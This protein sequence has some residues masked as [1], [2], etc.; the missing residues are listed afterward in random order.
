[1]FGVSKTEVLNVIVTS[2]NF[3]NDI[4]SLLDLWPS[5]KLVDFYMPQSLKELYPL[6][7]IIIDT[8]STFSSYKHKNTLKFLVGASPGGLL[9]F[10]QGHM[11]DQPATDKL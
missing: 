2:I 9:K 1:M 6:T 10:G 4:W 7:R 11:Q 8:R 5:R 3:V